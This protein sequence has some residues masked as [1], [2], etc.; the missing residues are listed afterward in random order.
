MRRITAFFTAL[1]LF[2]VTILGV[3]KYGEAHQ[4]ADPHEVGTWTNE[5]KFKSWQMIEKNVDENTMVVFGSSELEH[6]K[7]TPYHPKSIFADQDFH[8]MLVGAGYYQSLSHAITL[9]AIA[10]KLK[11]KQVVLILSPQWFRK[12]GVLPKA[13]ASRFS[14]ANYIEMLKNDKISRDTKKY[15]A[16]RSVELL[17]DDPTEQKR[18]ERYNRV[19]LKQQGS[20]I[21]ELYCTFYTSFLNEKVMQA[22]AV[23]MKVDG[24]SEKPEK[25]PKNPAINFENLRI[26]AGVEGNEGT[27]SNS[28]YIKDE[29]YNKRL[30][31][32]LV[33]RQ[34][35]GLKGSYSKSP[36]Y[37]DLRCFLDVCKENGIT[38]L[39]VS[40]PVNG[41]WYDY[42]GFTRE[43]REEYYQNIRDIAEEYQVQLADFADREYEKYF[44]EDTM[45]LGWK[46]WVDVSESIYDFAE[47]TKK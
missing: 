22:A 11:N 42:T 20:V 21:D 45:H 12:K 4:T 35:S 18:I 30:K 7:K 8:T 29:Y 13:Y 36:E 9:S 15:I 39:L 32:V 2:A 41:W 26:Q 10:P 5:A 34:N 24:I 17:E 38:P 19:C 43:K 47:Q 37:E 33:K 46:G 1:V 25:Q 3:H 23:A 28:F 16:K 27:K 44:L 40:V 31:K 14:E 6:G